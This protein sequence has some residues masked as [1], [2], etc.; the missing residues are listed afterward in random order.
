MADP[1]FAITITDDQV[2]DA[3]RAPRR[4]F[5]LK[6][7]QVAKALGVSRQTVY[8]YVRSGTLHG[9]HPTG[10]GPGRMIRIRATEVAD[11]LGDR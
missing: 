7:D 10:V 5:L 4:G 3:L 8:R 6:P 9:V 11:M 2:D 1:D